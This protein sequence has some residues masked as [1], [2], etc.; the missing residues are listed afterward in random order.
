MS[1]K[2][3]VGQNKQIKKSVGQ[4]A[5]RQVTILV[6]GYCQTQR[7]FLQVFGNWED[8]R[9]SNEES[10]FSILFKSFQQKNKFNEDKF[11]WRGDY[12]LILQVCVLNEVSLEWKV[13][14][15]EKTHFIFSNPLS[16]KPLFSS[17]AAPFLW[18]SYW[19]IV[20]LFD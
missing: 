5:K 17:S 2:K 7:S 19:K 20:F 9:I 3:S 4:T 12:H 10:A 6:F 18:L 13:E 16:A 11:R 14:M 1:F 15:S 8:L